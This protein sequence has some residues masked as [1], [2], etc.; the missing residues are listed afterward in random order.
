MS[1]TIRVVLVALTLSV[2]AGCA[3]TPKPATIKVSIEVDADV[4]PDARG[5]PS[6]IV[7]RYFELKTLAAFQGAD[8]FSLFERDKETLG[9]EL[10]AREE[11]QLM[12]KDQRKFERKLQLD[13][14]YI[15]IVAA[16][17]DLER[18][19][20]RAAV[21]VPAEKVTPLTIKVDS[22]SVTAAAR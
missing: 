15:D 18:A 7:L 16:F 2:L 4:N 1:T 20:W 10:V 19:Q 3:S 14:R 21:A 8:F 9:A 5:R 22:R 11:L 13:T 17:R 6:P 12:P